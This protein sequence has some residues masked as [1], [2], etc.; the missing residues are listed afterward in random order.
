MAVRSASGQG[1]GSRSSRVFCGR[2]S[3][4]TSRYRREEP[5]S[6][7]VKA[8]SY[9]GQPLQFPLTIRCVRRRD[10]R[11]APLRGWAGGFVQ[12]FCPMS[13]YAEISVRANASAPKMAS[14]ETFWRASSRSCRVCRLSQN[15]GVVPKA[16]P[17][18]MASQAPRRRFF[19]VS[20]YE[21]RAESQQP[22]CPP[23]PILASLRN[24]PITP[25]FPARRHGGAWLCPHAIPAFCP[26]PGGA[27]S[28]RREITCRYMRPSSLPAMT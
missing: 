3:L 5:V 7:V 16:W 6:R 12:G 18:R 1:A 19:P 10:C 17:S 22:V 11:G 15:S 24:P 21:I 20:C 27:E 14:G 8:C 26:D 9:Q 28:T 13:P 2:S 23:K 25:R 4:K